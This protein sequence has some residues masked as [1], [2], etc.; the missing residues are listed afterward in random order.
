M[1]WY[2]FPP[3]QPRE[4]KDGIKVRSQR[5][6]F[7][8]TWWGKRWIKV[9]EGFGWSARLQRGRS[10]ARKGQVMDFKLSA[11]TVRAKVQGSRPK[12]YVVSISL[13]PLTEKSWEKVMVRLSS[14][15]G[16][17][18]QL[19]AGEMPEG[20]EKVF[21]E[22]GA[23][24]FPETDRGFRAE[25]NCPDWANP[26]KHIAALHYVLGEAFDRDPFLLF[27]L[28]G[29]AKDQLL[30]RLSATRSHA[31]SHPRSVPRASPKPTK[32]ELPADP[33]SFW[34]V[35]PP[36]PGETVVTG[37][38]KGQHAL[39]RTLGTP[40]FLRG[41]EDLETRLEEAYDTVSQRARG[42]IQGRDATTLAPKPRLA[43]ERKNPG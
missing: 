26:C 34:G 28:R 38:P 23:S 30:A 31:P 29:M 18:A 35:P 2:Y 20:I 8:S 17:T 43:G 5:G 11:G 16:F 41:R 37:G 12:P 6:A 10:Y 33:R 9:L 13:S 1:S 24:L 21:E 3:S 15:A 4:V 19:L 22:T 14:K 27:A 36:S 7:G 25:C 40:S 32:V 39:L 42:H